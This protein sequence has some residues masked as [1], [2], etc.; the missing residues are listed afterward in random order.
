MRAPPNKCTVETPYPG[1]LELLEG[2]SGSHRL[3]ILANQPPGLSARLQKQ[4]LGGH[5]QCIL[6]SGDAGL[7][8]PGLRFY[9]LAAQATGVEPEGIAMVGDRLDNDIRAADAAG[10]RSILIRRGGGPS[11]P[12]SDPDQEQSHIRPTAVIQRLGELPQAL[13]RLRRPPD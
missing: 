10:M 2:L 4:G 7:S 11:D 1:V 3:G 6:G 8:K 9:Q 13:A 12:L 5:F